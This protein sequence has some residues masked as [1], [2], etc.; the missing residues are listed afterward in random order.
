MIKRSREVALKI[1]RS[2]RRL[3]DKRRFYLIHGRCLSLV[4]TY[5]ISS[6]PPVHSADLT[7]WTEYNESGELYAEIRMDEVIVQRTKAVKRSDVLFWDEE[8]P[9]YV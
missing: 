1:V 7:A 6:C 3:T 5:L 9:M 2:L 8:L 4:Q